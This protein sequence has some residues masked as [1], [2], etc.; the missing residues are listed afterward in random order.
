MIARDWCVLAT[1]Q[2]V[3]CKTNA[4]L[5]S[6]STAVVVVGVGGA[7]CQVIIDTRAPTDEPSVLVPVTNRAHSCRKR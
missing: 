3:R 5:G 1:K 4:I 6:N 2:K 7:A